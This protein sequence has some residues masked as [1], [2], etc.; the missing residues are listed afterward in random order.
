MFP[1]C[2]SCYR[3]CLPS[4]GSSRVCSPASAVLRSVPTPVASSDGAPF[5][6]H[7]RTPTVSI[8]SLLQQI[9][10]AAAGLE[11]S[12]PVFPYRYWVE[13]RN[14]SPRFLGNPHACMPCSLTPVE[15][16]CQAIAASPC[17]LPPFIER[18]LP[19]YGHFEAQSHGLHARCLRFAAPVTRTPRKT[20][21]R[22][23]ASLY[24]AGFVPAGFLT[25]FHDGLRRQSQATKLCLAHINPSPFPVAARGCVAPHPLEGATPGTSLSF[26]ANLLSAAGLA[27][28][29]CL[30]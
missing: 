7:R 11:S 17:G 16:R 20:R 29:R 14:G 5:S 30:P 9:D 8:A 1:P 27:W 24:R 2:D 13:E 28:H 15:L 22:W 18:R 23:V 3:R 12:V 19:R 26:V 4:T 25:P 10:T 6:S 21:F